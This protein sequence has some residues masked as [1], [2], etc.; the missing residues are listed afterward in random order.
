MPLK[1]FVWI[2]TSSPNV[3]GA[4]IVVANDLEEAKRLAVEEMEKQADDVSE[5]VREEFLDIVKGD[6]EK[7]PEVLTQP[8][9]IDGTCHTLY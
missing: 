9:A 1:T 5:C 2:T 3:G 4:V 6:L 7:P 8:R